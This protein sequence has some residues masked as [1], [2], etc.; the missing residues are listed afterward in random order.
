VPKSFG[1]RMLMDALY[2]SNGTAVAVSDDQIQAA[3][4]QLGRSEGI[5]AAP[6]G[7]ATAAALPLLLERGWLGRDE[8]VVLLNTGTGLKYITQ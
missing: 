2:E 1:D 4:S 6:E 5:F 7:A 8:K 3:Q